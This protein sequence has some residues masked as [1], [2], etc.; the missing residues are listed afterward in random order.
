[1]KPLPDAFSAPVEAFTA[2][3]PLTIVS[4]SSGN[5]EMTPE[6]EPDLTAALLNVQVWK[7]VS[8][9]T[10]LEPLGASA[11]HSALELAQLEQVSVLVKLFAV[12]VESVTLSV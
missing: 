6:V 11:I 1:M 4:S 10:P 8:G 12:W 7:L 3:E 5:D 9:S 2:L